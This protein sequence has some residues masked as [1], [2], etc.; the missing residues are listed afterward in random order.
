MVENIKE[1][2][3]ELGIEFFFNLGI[4]D[5]GGKFVFNKLEDFF[6]VFDVF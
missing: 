2:E 6:F 4:R 5:N 3:V 1:F